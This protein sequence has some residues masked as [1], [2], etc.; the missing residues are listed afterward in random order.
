[1][2]QLITSLMTFLSEF[3]E[4]KFYQKLLHSKIPL[5]LFV[6]KSARKLLGSLQHISTVVLS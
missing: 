2:S 1:M 4:T 5:K 6:Q 3:S